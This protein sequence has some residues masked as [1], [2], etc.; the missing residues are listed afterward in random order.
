[1]STSGLEYLRT[2]RPESNVKHEDTYK[3]DFI[4]QSVDILIFSGP[5]AAFARGTDS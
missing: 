1:M 5:D 4:K 2:L 3:K